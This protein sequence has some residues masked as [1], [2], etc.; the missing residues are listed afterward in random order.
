MNF[1]RLERTISVFESS[2]PIGEENTLNE[3][4]PREKP[5]VPANRLK[6]NENTLLLEKIFVLSHT[7]NEAPGT[8]QYGDKKHFADGYRPIG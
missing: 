8:S 3:N 6:I 2:F 5:R 7:D 1:V 4:D